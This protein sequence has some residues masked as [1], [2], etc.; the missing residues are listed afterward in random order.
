M[1][2]LEKLQEAIVRLPS[3]VEVVGTTPH[4]ISFWDESNENNLFQVKSSGVLVNASV[5]EKV[6]NKFESHSIVTTEFVG[7][8]P[9]TEMLQELHEANSGLIVVGS[10]IA[11]QAYPGLV[12]GLCPQAGFERVPPAEKRMSQIK[13]N[14]Y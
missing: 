14:T 10:I 12:F 9:T 3:G 7:N 4:P 5:V 6:V 11:A 1:T 8:K 13:F 2:D